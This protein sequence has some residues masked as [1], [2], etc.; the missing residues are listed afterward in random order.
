M[1]SGGER[2]PSR[3]KKKATTEVRK[4][5]IRIFH[6]G[7]LL[8]GL[9]LFCNQLEKLELEIACLLLYCQSAQLVSGG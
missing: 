6:I 7:K 4:N 3:K 8:L 2:D 1:T 9:K 5:N